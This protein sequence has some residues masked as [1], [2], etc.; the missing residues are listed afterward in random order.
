MLMDFSNVTAIQ[1]P[2]GN[3][4]SIADKDNNIL[5]RNIDKYAYGIRWTTNGGTTCERIGN[6]DFHKTLPIQSKFKC[7]IHQGTDI[8]YYLNPLDSRFVEEDIRTSFTY[9]GTEMEVTACDGLP[10]GVTSCEEESVVKCKFVNKEVF[11]DYRFL[12]SYVYVRNNESTNR[13]AIGR[14]VYIDTDKCEAYIDDSEKMISSLYIYTNGINYYHV[15]DILNDDLFTQD[16]TVELG[17]SLNG[18]DGELGVDTGGKF[19]QWSID[20]GGV[21]TGNEVWISE[22]KCVSYAKEVK[23]HIVG[24]NRACLLRTAFNDSK[25]GWIGTLKSNT[26]VNVINYKTN[27]RGGNNPSNF[28]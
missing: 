15:Y 22:H 16:C 7:C 2:E 28:D 1:I 18:Y 8:Q 6:L 24:H 21:G 4:V 26:A 10:S 12:Y 20:R 13:R 27:L 9:R 23:R 17:A 25:W 19:Y 3:V 14:I 5:W 11:S